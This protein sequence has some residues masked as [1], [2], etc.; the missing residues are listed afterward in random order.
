MKI[1]PCCRTTKYH[2]INTYHFE[3]DTVRCEI[4]DKS[5]NKEELIIIQKGFNPTTF[6][7][8]ECHKSLEEERL[9]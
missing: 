3:S 5:W 4:C 2:T 1:T 6:F 9:K 7:C 8:D